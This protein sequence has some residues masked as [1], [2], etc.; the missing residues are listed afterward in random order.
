VDQGPS[1]DGHAGSRGFFRSLLDGLVAYVAHHARLD[2]R[3]KDGF[4]ER[5]HLEQAERQGRLANPGKLDGPDPPKDLVYL[6]NWWRELSWGLGEHVTWLD[7]DAW[8]RLTDRRPHPFEVRALMELARAHRNP[9][10]EPDDKD[11]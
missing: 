7:V 5:E 1:H 3:D 10:E 9:G 6:L 4:T 11:E 8:A 2:Q